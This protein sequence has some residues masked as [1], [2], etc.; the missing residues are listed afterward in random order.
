MATDKTVKNVMSTDVQYIASDSTLDQAASKMRDLD[1]GFL[2]I[3]DSPNGTLQGVITDR[4]IVIRGL[5]EGV[6][7]SEATVGSVKSDRV[8]YC[9]QDDDIERA[10]DSMRDQQVYRLVVLDSQDSKKICGVITLNDIVRHQES[11]IASSAAQGIA[12]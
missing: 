4:D 9:F 2:P 10:A 5:A 12:S 1:C 3:G 6:N 11:Q 8:L 7:S